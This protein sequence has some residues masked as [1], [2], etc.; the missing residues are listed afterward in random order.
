M[1]TNRDEASEPIHQVPVDGILDLHHF[2]P[3]EVADLVAHY[4]D[5]CKEAG[6][7]V[8]RIIH[9]KGIGV[10]RDRVHALLKKRDDVARFGL[11][12]TTGS[13]WGATIV[14]LKNPTK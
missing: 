14:W 2:R 3:G 4:I 10:L 1:E 13:G 9:G 7:P 6:L 8:V 11:D 12:S 5:C